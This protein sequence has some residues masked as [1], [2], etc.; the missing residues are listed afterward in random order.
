MS[1]RLL[2]LFFLL[3][4]LPLW[5]Q[6]E[7]R[8]YNDHPRIWLDESRLVRVQRD[9]ERNTVRWLRLKEL[10]AQPEQ[11]QE[12]AFAAALAYQ[13]SGDE[14]FGRAAAEWALTAAERN[15]SEAGDLRQGS[16]VFDWCQPLL[17][18]EERAKIAAGLATAISV[19]ADAGESNL[20]RTRDA[21][22]ASIAVSGTWPGAEE[23]TGKL[24]NQHWKANLVPQMEAGQALD[25]AEELQAAL[26]IC[27][28]VRHNLDRDLWGESPQ[29]FRDVA[30]ARILSYLPDDVETK[31]GRVHRP[32]VVPGGSDLETEA[33]VGR[34]AEMT[35]VGF[36][37]RSRS[38]QFLQGWL[39][40]DAH[41]LRGAY[42]AP[43]EFLWLN[44]YLPGLS[45]T[46]GPQAAYDPTRGRFFARSGWGADGL[47]LGFFDG[48][49]LRYESGAL[50]PVEPDNRAE[51]IPFP[52]F[53]IA[54]PEENAK[55]QA[56]V[57]EGNPAYGQHVYLLGMDDERRYEIK[58]ADSAWH[59]YRP[60]GGVIP[61]TNE[62]GLGLA[63]L[64]FHQD[65]T[66][67]IRPSKR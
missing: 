61:L 47:W 35:L 5:P 59:E 46:S 21:L 31:E 3:S 6:A 51:A 48:A 54:L 44:P 12:P 7:Y 13:A 11:L 16:L 29:A 9:A 55:F 60:Q 64:D 58:I 30:M 65:Q 56:K 50:T 52:G 37:S 20:Q 8:V 2:S 42:G 28:A 25:R 1:A 33:I 22:L 19:A 57:L 41:T 27:V 24:L 18:E 67:R 53:A 39:R 66:I 14:T 32:S 63:E 23:A 38:S 10:L 34:V 40:S 36:D 49:L 43:Y 45:P 26:E 4:C 15:F 17:N 62:P